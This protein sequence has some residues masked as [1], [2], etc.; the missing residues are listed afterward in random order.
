MDD[1]KKELLKIKKNLFVSACPGAGKT[2]LLLGMLDDN[3]KCDSGYKWHIVLTHTNAAADEINLRLDNQNIRNDRVWCGTIHSFLLEW[4]VRKYA[5]A[6]A[7]TKDGIRLISERE[8]WDLIRKIEKENSFST[9]LKFTWDEYGAPHV[10]PF[11]LLNDSEKTIDDINYETMVCEEYEKNK[12]DKNLIDFN[13]ILTLSRDFLTENEKIAEYLSKLIGY[14]YLDE[15][16]DTSYIQLEVLSFVTR[17]NKTIILVVGD[18][19]QAIYQDLG[20]SVKDEISIKKILKLDDLEVRQL[21]GCY[22]STKSLVDYYKKY[23]YSKSNIES[24]REDLGKPPKIINTLKT[25]LPGRV[26]N[27]VEAYN[28]SKGSVEG[29]AIIGPNRYYLD[30]LINSIYERSNKF[31]FDFYSTNPL[32]RLKDTIY[33]DLVRLVLL[34]VSVKNY[35]SRHALCISIKD[36]I[37]EFDILS[38]SDL[39]KIVRKFNSKRTIF[40]LWLKDF[41]EFILCALP[42]SPKINSDHLI[43]QSNLSAF[44][45]KA[46]IISIKKIINKETNVVK[47]TTIHG[48]KGEEYDY[49]ISIG[50]HDQ[51]TPHSSTIEKG[52]EYSESIAKRLMFVAFSRAKNH[53]NIYIDDRR[54]VSPYFMVDT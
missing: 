26:I 3:I 49:V 16:Q 39:K 17:Y 48:C 46:D 35:R 5:G 34:D 47:V 33:F 25:D 51:V 27:L 10:E 7:R 24:I 13:D 2:K 20:V 53:M 37:P 29:L 19:D 45:V 15:S 14:I 8:H 32:Y 12:I 1:E 4:V 38:C 40:I 23:S 41:Y 11:C 21:T 36:K 54:V 31:V 42:R 9:R 50:Y 43:C 30:D 22:R 28:K 18:N 44:P 6:M 52:T